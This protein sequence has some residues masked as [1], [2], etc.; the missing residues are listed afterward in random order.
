MKFTAWIKKNGK[1][2]DQFRLCY[3]IIFA[4][5]DFPNTSSIKSIEKFCKKKEMT[6]EVTFA[7]NSTWNEFI[8]LPYATIWNRHYPHKSNKLVEDEIKV[9]L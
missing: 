1:R 2:D 7:F 4:N 3:Q 8:K 6:N 9:K 5:Y